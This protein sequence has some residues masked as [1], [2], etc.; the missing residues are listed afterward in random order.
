MRQ[1]GRSWGDWGMPSEY[2]SV[3]L[4]D[5]V[6]LATGFPFKST[7]YSNEGSAVRLLRGDNVAQG[8][9]RWED[10]K[11]WPQS[12]S[13]D[14][15]AYALREDDVV[16]AMDRPWIAAG[17]KFAHVRRADLPCLLVQRVARLRAKEALDSR[18][19]RYVIGSK[20]F[21]DY[22]LS[23]QTGTAVPHISAAQINAFE[24]LLPPMSEQRIAGELLGMLDD[25]IDLLRET[26]TTLESIGNALFKSWFIDFDAV[27]AKV[28][29][30]EPGG[31]DAA[32]AALFPAAFE[33]SPL[34]FTPK[35]WPIIKLGDVL[36]L[37]KGCSY[38]GNGLSDFDGAYM[39]NLGCFNAH[40]VFA[41]ER[42]KRYTGEYRPR[43]E[44]VAGDLIMANTDMTQA[45][46]ILGRPAFVPDGFEPGFISHH[47]FKVTIKTG[48]RDLAGALRLFLFFAL[49]H[50]A[51][52]E[53]AIGFATGTTVLALPATAVTECPS[54]M[55][56]TGVLLAFA[57]AASP[58]LARIRLNEKQADTLAN[59][60][61]ELLPRL[62]SG[63][64]R[65]PEVQAQ[66]EEAIA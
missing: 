35:G 57:A 23:V 63:K 36:E 6:D 5:H 2:T 52:R 53:R 8:A 15:Q 22:I 59:V 4:G 1:F 62:I 46:D 37:T 10:A 58:L 11:R 21:T 38:K 48:D 41:A 65:L 55:P 54:C 61:D 26:N 66:I 64:L 43:H 24:F 31:M 25:R 33:E 39:F 42:V 28:D 51:F 7:G 30:S 44:V 13:D 9:L 20:Q 16:L 32:T 50:D 56:P 40:R 19:L 29:G 49:Q 14:V 18:F 27:R 34:G 3:R 47:V 12:G 60:R 45:R 17:L